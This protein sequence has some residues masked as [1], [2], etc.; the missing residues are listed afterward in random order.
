MAN[1][2]PG[3]I[4][5]QFV[6][7]TTVQSVRTN[8][9]AAF[10]AAMIFIDETTVSGV[11]TGSPP[12]PGTDFELTA[13]NFTSLT[14]GGLRDILTTYFATNQI[15]PMFVAVWDESAPSYAGLTTAYDAL[16]YDAYFKT[17]YLAGLGSE[18]NQN[19][20]AVKLAELGFAD[21]GV[22]SQV[23]FGTTVADNLDPNSGTSLATAIRDSDGDAVLV[24]A[25]SSQD[26]DPWIDQL[27]VSLGLLNSSGTSIWNAL[28]MLSTSNR[29][30]SAA[31]TDVN[32]SAA[33]VA[34]LQGQNIGY[35]SYLG[36]GT[37][38]V[39]LYDPK[40]LLGVV[41]AASWGT[42]YLNYVMSIR[43]TEWLT[44][45]STPQGKRRN[46]SNYQAILGI[47]GATASPFTDKG[48]IGALEGFTIAI[49]PAFKDLPVSGDSF[50]VPHAW[51]A[52]FVQ[53]AREIN[54][55]GT[56]FIQE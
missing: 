52:T 43:S 28:D 56:L 19:A 14:S 18:A 35:W 21:T 6:H 40:T 53:N 25:D 15:A 3:S 36:N 54:V 41:Y 34:A 51:E 55:Q 26:T 50:I 47:V 33:D 30:S 29:G 5:Q 46:N 7:F 12:A 39:S 23:G 13:Q 27:G 11:W 10:G 48:G 16:K 22:F 8:P 37:P 24:Y 20:A 44:D 1:N 42:A 45:P 49:A 9:G 2:Y 4:A 31:D 17:M 32:L 38:F